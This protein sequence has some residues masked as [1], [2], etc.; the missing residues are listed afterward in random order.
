[1]VISVQ[2]GVRQGCPLSPMLINLYSELIMRHSLE[3]W[4]DGTVCPPYNAPR[5]NADSGITRSTVAPEIEPARGHFCLCNH[6][7]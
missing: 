3:K 6:S 5:Y 2:R 7:T 4:E 1:M